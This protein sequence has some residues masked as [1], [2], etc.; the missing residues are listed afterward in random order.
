[1]TTVG[2]I[3]SGRIGSTVA[4]LSVAAGHPVIMSNSRGPATLQDLVGELGPLA[5]AGTGAQAS[6]A[7][8]IV[9]VTIPLKA[10]RSVPAGPLAGKIVPKRLIHYPM[11]RFGTVEELA[12]TVAYLASDDAGFVTAAAFPIEGGITG[13]FT[14]PS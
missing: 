12:G 7:G 3:G 11:G 13:A 6:A 1:M 14:V 9:V 10:Y 2:F 4:R 5:R 8:D